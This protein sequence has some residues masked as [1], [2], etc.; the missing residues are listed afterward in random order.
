MSDDDCLTKAKS[1]KPRTA[2]QVEAFKKCLDAKQKAMNDKKKL[3]KDELLGKV[4]NPDTECSDDDIPVPPTPMKAKKEIKNPIPPTPMKAKKQPTIIYQDAT[5][6]EPEEESEE[7]VIIIK[8]KKKEKKVSPTK[9]KVKKIIV[10]SDSEEDVEEDVEE[11][12]PIQEPMRPL[13]SQQNKA[14]KIKIHHTQVK[15]PDVVF[16]FV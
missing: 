14:S 4:I 8:K 15:K 16:R 2:K 10:D 3:I 1:L 11:D 13:R 5:E 9:K 7:E 6:S 12:E